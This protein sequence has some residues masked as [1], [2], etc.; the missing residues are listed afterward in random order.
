MSVAAEVM[1]HTAMFL[2]FICVFFFTFVVNMQQRSVIS[3]LRNLVQQ[4]VG[5]YTLTQAGAEA[6]PGMRQQLEQQTVENDPSPTNGAIILGI[7]IGVPLI[8]AVLVAASLWMTWRHKESIRDMVLSS[9]IVL[10]F[11]AAAEFI[12]IGGF[13]LQMTSISDPFVQAQF[14]KAAQLQYYDC[15]QI[16]K[17]IISMF[18]FTSCMFSITP[19]P[20]W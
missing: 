2:A 7:S 1:M 13:V 4:Y 3:D 18:P 5:L 9:F 12:L 14:V 17:A 6:W 10:L 16:P 8:V 19:D 11:C 15:A 20:Q